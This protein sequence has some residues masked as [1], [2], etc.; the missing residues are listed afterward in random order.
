MLSREE[1][2]LLTRTGPETPMGS[3]MRRYWLPILLERE[4]VLGKTSRGRHGRNRLH[5][6]PFRCLD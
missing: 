5:E 4:E 3:V 1:N 2:E 6:G